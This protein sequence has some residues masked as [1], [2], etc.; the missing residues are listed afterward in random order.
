MNKIYVTK[1]FLPPFNEF[2]KR[3]ESVWESGILTNCGPHYQQLEVAL[4][5]HLGATNLTLLNNGTMALL[6]ALEVLEVEGEVITTPYSFVATS[7]SLLWRKC[8]PVF[9]DVSPTDCNID[10]VKVAQAI[11]S[12][13]NAIL[14]VHCYGFPCDVEALQEIAAKHGLKLIYDAAHAFGVKYRSSSILQ[15][16]DAST[17]SFHATK[18][19]NTIEGG[20][21]TFAS[22][23]NDIKARKLSNFG[24]DNEVS[25]SAIGLNFK[26]NEIQAVMGLAQL[27]YLDQ[28]SNKRKYIAQRYGCE[29]SGL[30]GVGFPRARDF[31]EINNSYYPIFVD[32]VEG[33]SR[34]DL[35]EFLKERG[36]YSRRYFYPLI[37]NFEIYQKTLAGKKLFLPVAESLSERVLCLPIYPS[38]SD[39]EQTRVISGIKEFFGAR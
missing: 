6:A 22:V 10:P 36:V 38:L 33:R 26:L 13:T 23:E 15:Y 28:I 1:P 32:P 35:Y 12:R 16:G 25:V 27:G 18:I 11:N 2:V 30:D 14:A 31:S 9:V 24:F 37:N 21:V 34:N 5:Q 3:L 17:L 7:H 19:F 20:S 39:E 8:K 4:K 29:L